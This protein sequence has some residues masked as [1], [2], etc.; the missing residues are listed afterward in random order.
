MIYIYLFRKTNSAKKINPLIIFYTQTYNKK[1]SLDDILMV[2]FK[3]GYK[4]AKILANQINPDLLSCDI[5][6]NYIKHL[7]FIF[8]LGDDFIDIEENIQEKT[9]TIWTLNLDNMDPIFDKFMYYIFN[10]HSS[11]EEHFKLFPS[12]HILILSQFSLIGLCFVIIQVGYKY[13]YISDSLVDKW[14]NSLHLK[15]QEKILDINYYWDYCVKHYPHIAHQFK[16]LKSILKI[17]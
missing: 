12:N 15:K 2:S 3:K 5:Y 4:F 16:T 7:A 10:I 1:S 14:S 9:S 6:K 11:Y 8:Q 17:E 13:K